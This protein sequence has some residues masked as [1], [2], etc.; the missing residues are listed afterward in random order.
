MA[1]S[2]RPAASP[3]QTQTVCRRCSRQHLWFL[4]VWFVVGTASAQDTTYL[5]EIEAWRSEAA[6]EYRPEAIAAVD[7]STQQIHQAGV[8]LYSETLAALQ[9]AL[10]MHNPKWFARFALGQ[11]PTYQESLT[12]TAETQ[13]SER[14]FDLNRRDLGLQFGRRLHDWV[15]FGGLQYSEF[16]EHVTEDVYTLIAGENRFDVRLP[17]RSTSSWEYRG[18]CLGISHYEPLENTP[19]L[20]YA[21]VTG[22]WLQGEARYDNA[23]LDLSDPASPSRTRFGTTRRDTELTGITLEAAVHWRFDRSWQMRIGYRHQDWDES[24]DLVLPQ[25][26]NG[27][28][29]LALGYHF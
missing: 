25:V 20:I 6:L 17:G 1:R 10:E 29:F 18:G 26:R 11:T 2:A 22:L 15:F 12:T 7:P 13:L 23:L 4:I 5:L 21:A 8:P 28:A 9:L 14:R 19:L 27:G 3:T 16:K 24:D